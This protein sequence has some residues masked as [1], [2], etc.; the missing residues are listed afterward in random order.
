MW[1]EEFSTC[2]W[3]EEFSIYQWIGLVMTVFIVLVA[4]T[5]GRSLPPDG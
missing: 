3:I 5:S 1:I 2:Q 4:I